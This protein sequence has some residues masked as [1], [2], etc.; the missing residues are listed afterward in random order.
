MAI[1]KWADCATHPPSSVLRMAGYQGIFL[2]AGTPQLPKNGSRVLYQSYAANGLDSAAIFEVDTTDIYRP[3]LAPQHA[4]DTMSDVLSWGAPPTMAIEATADRH[5]SAADIPTAT[6]Y[7]RL[8]YQTCKGRGW[9]GPVGGYGFSEFT[10]AITAAGVADWTHVA[11]AQSTVLPGDTFWQENNRRD[12]PSGYQVDINWQYHPLG[13]TNVF[14]QQQESAIVQAAD[15]TNRMAP[16]VTQI[17]NQLMGPWPSWVPG[18]DPKTTERTLVDWVRTIDA[19]V[20]SMTGLVQTMAAA[21]KNPDITKEELTSLFDQALASHLDITGSLH[22]GPTSAPVTVA[23]SQN[24]P[25][26]AA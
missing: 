7:Q 22:I 12:Y 18:S 25:T 15:L 13:D 4:L 23:P 6:E 19:A 8:F 17:L 1:A 2:Y 20:F 16:A 26:P 5:L 14:T 10:Q 3:D 9:A 24:P 11:G 21:M